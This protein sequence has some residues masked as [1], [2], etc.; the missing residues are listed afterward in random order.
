MENVSIWMA[1]DLMVDRLISRVGV[2]RTIIGLAAYTDKWHHGISAD[3][4]ARKWG[5]TLDK[6]KADTP[7]NNPG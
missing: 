5:I 7:I 4:L 2:K 6:F 3:L 1:Q